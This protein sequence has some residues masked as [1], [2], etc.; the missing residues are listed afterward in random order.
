[1][2][3][4]LMLGL[5]FSSSPADSVPVAVVP[6]DSLRSAVASVPKDSL[7]SVRD[8]TKRGLDTLH[9][10]SD[11][12]WTLLF[13]GGLGAQF[14]NF[15]Q[16][17]RFR[18][19]A[20]RI[21][22]R[23]TL[24]SLQE[25]QSSE[26]APV[27]SIG[28]ALQWKQALRLAVEGQWLV[29]WNQASAQRVDSVVTKDTSCDWSFAVQVWR[30]GIGP[31]FLIPRQILSIQGMGPLALEVRGWLLASSLEGRTTSHG[32]GYG[33]SAG[34]SSNVV[35]SRFLQWGGRVRWHQESV[36]GSGTWN[37]L[38]EPGATSP[39]RPTWQAGGLEITFEGA[40]RLEW[41]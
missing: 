3:V 16:R 1:M 27:V 8:T 18:E 6:S 19:D 11:P 37:D 26:I 25:Y 32:W 40:F 9:H 36:R 29:W 17:S 21:I 39:G 33:W 2:H 7:P 30:L 31:D 5:L 12:R 22:A 23:D 20:A 35:S 41:F 15:S 13:K 10:R 34:I 14:P 28:A 24:T 4:W 38:L